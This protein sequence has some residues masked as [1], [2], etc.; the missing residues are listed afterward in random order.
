MK[1]VLKRPS[2][3]LRSTY[4]FYKCI[5]RNHKSA[6]ILTYFSVPTILHFPEIF[7]KKLVYMAYNTTRQ[8]C[9]KVNVYISNRYHFVFI[10]KI[11]FL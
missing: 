2:I 5:W 6:F 8:T 10:K 1:S 9:I 7:P 3:L 11:L 4:F